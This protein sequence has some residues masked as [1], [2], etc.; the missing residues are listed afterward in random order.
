MAHTWKEGLQEKL[1]QLNKVKNFIRLNDLLNENQIPYV[2]LKGILLS[3]RIY[4]DPTVRLTNDIDI[5][6]EEE[7]IDSVIKVLFENNF[8]FSHGTIWP[9]KKSRQKQILSH[10]HHL[11]FFN[12]G[13]F[14][15]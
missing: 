8:E 4:N 5:L 10:F 12:K 9:Q 11:T 6:I 2:N 15:K 3:N 1:K 14:E 7:H 13:R